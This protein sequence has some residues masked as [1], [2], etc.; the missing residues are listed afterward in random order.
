MGSIIEVCDVGARYGLHP[1]WRNREDFEIC[2]HLI[3]ADSDEVSRLRN[4]FT[5]DRG[6]NTFRVYN[7]FLGSDGS[8]EVF[9]HLSNKAMSGSFL[10]RQSRLFSGE[11]AQQVEVREVRSLP[12]ISLDRLLHEVPIDFLKVDTE[13]SELQVLLGAKSMLEKSI[14]G[15]RAEVAFNE[16]FI[17]APL[18]WEV[19]KFLRS[20]GFDI[21]N[22]EFTGKGDLQHSFV[23][24]ERRFG[25]LNLT[26]AIW[27]H[28]DFTSIPFVAP[29]DINSLIR[30]LKAVVFMFSNHS[31]DLALAVLSE[32][33]DMINSFNKDDSVSLL[34]TPL[35]RLVEHHLYSLK[36]CPGQ[37]ADDHAGW[38]RKIFPREMRTGTD[39]MSSLDLNP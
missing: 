29:T 7:A 3:E 26:D 37:S 33:K 34:L 35:S 28:R 11:R 31:P 14:I 2:F 21:L 5:R 16:V 24:P 12:S 8:D 27:I 9:Y 25:V 30:T 18:F 39:F 4:K 17:G 38:F 1:S 13:G 6:S 32:S 23:N 36:W 19:D 15:I 22:F 20:L 10:R